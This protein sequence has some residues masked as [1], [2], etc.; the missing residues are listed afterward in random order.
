MSLKSDGEAD[1]LETQGR[2]TVRLQR[3]S[4][5]RIPSCSVEVSLCPIKAFK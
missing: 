3:Q 2:V 4:A 5:G 1:R